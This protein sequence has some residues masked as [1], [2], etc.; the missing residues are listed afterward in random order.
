MPCKK[1]G[2]T[3]GNARLSKRASGVVFW[4]FW[5]NCRSVE[6]EFIE[7]HQEDLVKP[8]FGMLVG[9]AARSPT[10]D[11]DKDT[12]LVMARV[13]KGAIQNTVASDFRAAAKYWR[14]V[15]GLEDSVKVYV[16]PV[17]KC[18]GEELL[19][20]F[21]SHLQ[22][23]GWGRAVQLH[24]FHIKA[25]HDAIMSSPARVE[26]PKDATVF[27][28]PAFHSLLV[29][30]YIDSD[31]TAIS[32]L[33]CMAVS[34]GMLQDDVWHRNAGYDHFISAGTCHPYSVCNFLE[35]DVT[36][37]HPFAVNVFALVGGVRQIGHPDF[38][39]TP[40]QGLQRLRTLIVPFPVTL[41]CQRLLHVSQRA[42]P[43][44][45]AFVGTENSR[46][47]RIFRD[48]ME[49]TKMPYGNDPRFHIRILPDDDIGEGARKIALGTEG[50][51]SIDEL[52]SNSQFCLV[53][54]GHVYDLGRRAYDA[55]ARACILVVVAVEPMF[56]AVPFAW[57]IPWEEFAIFASVRNVEDAAKVLDS[58]SQAVLEESG[59]AAI[60]ARREA[61]LKYIPKLFLPPHKNCLPGLPTAMDGILKEI[62]VRQAAW[63]AI[64]T[65]RPPSLQNAGQLTV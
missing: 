39:F 44:D 34:W 10:D 59:R 65:A 32:V 12:S 8:T 36:N 58:L 60:S 52:Y 1:I 26:D 13:P 35:C 20:L 40:G 62:A 43:I 21:T 37:F 57:Q 25:V 6:A 2:R 41:D 53:L 30:R 19:D 61:M 54:P 56:V 46:A 23:F 18:A 15:Q 17:P 42:R 45:V 29:E 48:L 47:R 22:G 24:A 27:Y 50:D 9:G 5:L 4:A 7:D 51:T 55:M 11:P 33:N 31:M 49:D 3:P 64:S 63:A 28:I 38:V 14:S 16:H